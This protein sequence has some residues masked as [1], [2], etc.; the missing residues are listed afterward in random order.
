MVVY[1]QYI[2][3]KIKGF[4]VVVRSKD[5]NVYAELLAGG[6][7]KDFLKIEVVCNTNDKCDIGIVVYSDKENPDIVS[8]DPSYSCVMA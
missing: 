2:H 3:A 6:I 8:Q 7:S 4:A 5:T 1:R